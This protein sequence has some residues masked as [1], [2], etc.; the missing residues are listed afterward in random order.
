[1]AGNAVIP[2]C[3]FGGLNLFTATEL[4]INA[5]LVQ[6]Y[7]LKGRVKDNLPDRTINM[8]KYLIRV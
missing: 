7:F 1:M 6:M 2:T 8:I 3:H 5:C 4:N